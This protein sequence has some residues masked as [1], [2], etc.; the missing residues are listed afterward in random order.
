MSPNLNLFQL[1]LQLYPRFES[2]CLC[3]TGGTKDLS[4]LTLILRLKWSFETRETFSFGEKRTQQQ[5]SAT[6]HSQNITVRYQTGARLMIFV[7]TKLT[8]YWHCDN[9]LGQMWSMEPT[10][11]E[12]H[13]SNL[14]VCVL[15]S[16]MR[17]LA[18]SGLHF[19]LL[20]VD[21]GEAYLMR[22]RYQCLY[23]A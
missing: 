19:I 17:C 11:A 9:Y 21:N 8:S 13:S 22:C 23:L 14:I 5:Q 20:T 18:Q 6:C 2:Q 1:R 3:E 7:C 12:W 10:L 16:L 15:A 4:A